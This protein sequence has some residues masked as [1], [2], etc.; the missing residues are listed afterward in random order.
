MSRLSN[1]TF[2]EIKVGA[3]ETVSRTL[4]ATDV[5]ALALAAG[6]VEGFHLEGGSPD[7]R[8]SAQGASAIA[9]VAGL[10]NR[11]LPG[12]GSAIIGT[13]F[14]YSGACHVG[15][16]LTATVTAKARHKRTHTIDFLCTCTNQDGVT[17]VDGVAMVEA[18]TERIAYA[19]VATPELILRRNDGFAKL[20][21][22]CEALP[23]VTCAVVHPCDRDSLLGPIEAAKR[24]LIVPVLVGPEA[25]I[26]A[27]ARAE[28]VDLSPF[29]IVPVEHSHAAAAKAVELARAGHVDALMKGSLH[30]DELMGA[31]VSTAD[32]LRTA[33]RISHV[34]VM[35]VPTYPRLLMVTDAAINLYPN[36]EDKVDICQNAIELAHILGIAKPRVAILSAVEMINPRIPGTLDAAALCKMADRGQIEGGI[37]DGPLAFDNAISIEAARTKMIDSPVA[38]RADILLVPDLEAGNM[39]AKQLQ[40]LAGADSAGIVLGTRVPIVLTSR[41]DNVRTRLASAAVMKLVASAR[42]GKLM[43]KD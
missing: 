18:P 1:R 38:G 43:P 21:K 28:G 36:L 35:D 19:D 7:D 24:G 27:V 26:R 13:A 4:T 41:S 3:T 15:D 12:P 8:I 2:D 30:T 37:L 39:L 20:F 25:R 10:L 14:R 22:R 9:L 32:G 33:R 16:T 11:R 5:E 42:R 6:D 40:Y 23:P 29:Q 34:F 31:V 17:L